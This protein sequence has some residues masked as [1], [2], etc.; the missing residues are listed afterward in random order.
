MFLT[1][2]QNA[3]SWA[4]DLFPRRMIKD[5]R[6]EAEEVHS[7]KLAVLHFCKVV[8]LTALDMSRT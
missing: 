4:R 6:S 1:D 7:W 3:S 8:V 2:G 5:A